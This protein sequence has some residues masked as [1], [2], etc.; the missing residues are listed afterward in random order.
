MQVQ[1]ASISKTAS[2]TILKNN[3]Y[4]NIEI[5]NHDGAYFCKKCKSFTQR[6]LFFMRVIFLRKYQ[7]R[8][9]SHLKKNKVYKFASK[10]ITG[11]QKIITHVLIEITIKHLMV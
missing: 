11:P 5:L 2:K 4:F 9:W 1:D 7:V 6:Y 3:S 10:I 8:I